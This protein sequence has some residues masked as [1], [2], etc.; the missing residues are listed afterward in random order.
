VLLRRPEQRRSTSGTAIEAGPLF[1]VVLAGERPLGP[2]LAEDSVL[3]GREPLPPRFVGEVLG[4]PHGH[5]MPHARPSR[6]LRPRSST[7]LA[8]VR[9]RDDGC[10]DTVPPSPPAV[11]PR[12]RVRDR[13]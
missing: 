1:V 2:F 4:V 10:R 3:L 9:G 5:M 8:L 13:L 6:T 12:A 7:A 11:E